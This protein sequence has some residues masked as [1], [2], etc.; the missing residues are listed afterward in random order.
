MNDTDTQYQTAIQHVEMVI[1]LEK[2]IKECQKQINKHKKA[3]VKIFSK[4]L[5]LDL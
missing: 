1:A 3:Y 5:P 2:H 4:L